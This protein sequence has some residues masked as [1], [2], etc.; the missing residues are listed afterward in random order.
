[1]VKTE[2]KKPLKKENNTW[3]GVEGGKHRNN[4][5]DAPYVNN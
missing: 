2:K 5:R 3:K 4:L 1:M